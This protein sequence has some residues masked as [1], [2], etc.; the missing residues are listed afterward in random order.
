MTWSWLS[1]RTTFAGTIAGQGLF[2]ELFWL[3]APSLSVIPFQSSAAASNA[4]FGSASP[5]NPYS[6]RD[7]EHPRSRGVARRAGLARRSDRLEVVQRYA[8][9]LERR[10]RSRLDLS[11]RQ[12]A[13]GRDLHPVKGNWVYLYRA[14]DSTGANSYFRPG[15]TPCRKTLSGQSPGSAN[16]PHPRVINTDKDAAYPPAAYTQSRGRSSG[17]M[18]VS[19][20]AI[21]QECKEVGSRGQTLIGWLRA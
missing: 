20:S 18:S 3:S 11:Q 2:P 9:E 13:R 19:P 6:P 4:V 7:P 10:V 16:H 12:L 8:P 21:S 15:A 17:E 1:R 14:V 5:G